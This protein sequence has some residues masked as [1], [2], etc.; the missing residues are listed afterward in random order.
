MIFANTANPVRTPYRKQ[1]GEKKKS[2]RIIKDDH[3]IINNNNND[4]EAGARAAMLDRT[5]TANIF[6][7]RLGYIAGNYI[8][9]ILLC[10]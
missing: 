9:F 10:F 2:V 5:W 6:R 3:I 7:N 8:E 4:T 1:V